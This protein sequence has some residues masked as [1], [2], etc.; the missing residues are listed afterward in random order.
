MPSCKLSC[1]EIDFHLH[2][3][4]SDSLEALLARQV[5]PLT[6]LST[7][8]VLHRPPLV[9]CPQT[10]EMLLLPMAVASSVENGVL[11]RGQRQEGREEG[12]IDLQGFPLAGGR[13]REDRS[14][15]GTVV[16]EGPISGGE[17]VGEETDCV[18]PLP[19]E[20][21]H[22][23]RR[24]AGYEDA[25]GVKSEGASESLELPERVVCNS[26]CIEVRTCLGVSARSTLCWQEEVGGHL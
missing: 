21:D 13:S 25:E 4:A 8:H 9:R 19:G 16:E 20:P 17:T 23:S 12:T 2:E 10:K 3:A 11:Y 24:V 22:S 14:P 18:V 26:P 1:D 5:Q 6:E 15:A 7:V